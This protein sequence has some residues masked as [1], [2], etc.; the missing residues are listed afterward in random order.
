[1]PVAI[2]ELGSFQQT[3]QRRQLYKA[4]LMNTLGGSDRVSQN[5]RKPIQGGSSGDL[6]KATAKM[7]M[8]IKIVPQKFA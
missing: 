1:M 7:L 3:E 4:F 6:E 8:A 5:L 2:V